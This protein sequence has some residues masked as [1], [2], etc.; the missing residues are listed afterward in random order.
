MIGSLRIK[1][2]LHYTRC[3]TSKYVT[4]GGIH[5][6]GLAPGQH[7]SEETL[8]RWRVAADFESYSD[9]LGFEPVPSA[10]IAVVLLQPAD[11]SASK[12]CQICIKITISTKTFHKFVFRFAA[13]LMMHHGLPQWKNAK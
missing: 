7:S 4:S 5:L 1:S 13:V 12:L 8:L 11:F 3:I 2:N 9:G 6:R 10:P